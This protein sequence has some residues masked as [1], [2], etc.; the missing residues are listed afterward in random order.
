MR[1]TIIERV[2]DTHWQQNWICAWRERVGSEKLQAIIIH[3]EWVKKALESGK[4]VLCEKP[5][6][7]TPEEAEELFALAKEKGVHLM[8]AFAY[9]HSP[10]VRAKIREV[11]AGPDIIVQ[12]YPN[13]ARTV[14]KWN[15]CIIH[16][17]FRANALCVH[18]GIQFLYQCV[19]TVRHPGNIRIRDPLCLICG[20]RGAFFATESVDLAFLLQM[21]EGSISV[22]IADPELFPAVDAINLF[23]QCFVVQII[24]IEAPYPVFSVSGVRIDLC[25]RIHTLLD[26][27]AVARVD[28]MLPFMTEVLRG[29]V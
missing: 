16:D 24:E 21:D 12:C 18:L 15:S 8:E 25:H 4:H 20:Q 19:W 1:K 6:V 9:L 3:F 10:L 22:V 17:C 23:A 27:D 13:V 2:Q 28:L 11:H 7:P 14:N 5:L 29:R 26:D